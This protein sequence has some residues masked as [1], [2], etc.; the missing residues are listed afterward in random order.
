MKLKYRGITY[1]PVP[2]PIRFSGYRGEGKYRGVPA[3]Y[4]AFVTDGSWPEVE[5]TYRGVP[6]KTGRPEQP[7][8]PVPADVSIPA[9]QEPSAK[10]PA[11]DELVRRLVMNRHQQVKKR[12]QSMLARM[13]AEVGLTV[14][15]AVHFRNHIQGYTP[16]NEWID[17]ERS[18]IAMS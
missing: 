11:L 16:Y 18:H 14:E 2:T 15:E 1:E 9:T 4:S 6:Y 3:K 10:L 12:E 7:I 17:Y 5:L 8:S 13:D